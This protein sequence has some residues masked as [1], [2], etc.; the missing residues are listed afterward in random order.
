MKKIT[1]ILVFLLGLFGG[2]YAQCIRTTQY[3]TATVASNNLGL[4]QNIS[5][6]NYTSEYAVLSGLV[7]GSNY[8]FTCVAT[9]VAK[10][11]TVTDL[12][13]AVIAS[14]PSPLTVSAIT[15]AD[16]RVHFSDD[17]A[18]ASTASCHVTTVQLLLSC[19][20]PTAA[21]VSA[22]TTTGATFTWTAGGSET[23]WEVLVLPLGA[24]APVATD[25]GTA[26]SSATYTE[27]TLNPSSSYQFYVRANCGSEF[28]PWSAA[29]SFASACDSVTDF[30]QN[31]DA[32]VAFPAC[33][34]RVGT[35]GSTNV[36]ASASAPSAPNV[37]YL[38][39]SSATSQGLVMMPL[40][41]NA[42]DG[43]HQLRFK[44]RGNFTAGGFIEVGYLTDSANAASFVSLQS[45]A[46]TSTTVYDNFVAVLGTAPGT[47]QT[48][49]FRHLGT[50][51]YSVLIDDVSWE[52]VPTV[53]PSCATNIVST[54]DTACGNYATT[55]TW[56][57]VPDANGYKLSMGTSPGASDV[58][59]NI[60][61]NANNY[62]FVG[63]FNAT[64]YY[65]IIPFNGA[66]NATGCTEETFTTFSSG[67]YCT[68]V[69]TSNDNSGITNVQLGTTDFPTTDVTYVDNTANPID[70][71][72][73]VNTNLQVTFATGF[74]Y[75][76]NV[77]IDFNDN[78]IFDST[79]LVKS[80]I[81]TV[82]TNPNTLDASFIMPVTAT[83]GQHRMR[84]GTADSGQN[85][86]NPCFS[87]TYGV[88]IDFMAN[89]VPAPS[90][91][92]PMSLVASSVT[93]ASATVSWTASTSTPANGY[94]YFVS[95]SN[96]APLATDAATG[97]VIGGIT[98]VNLTALNPAT[99]YYVWVRSICSTTDSSNW[100][101]AVSFTTQCV[102]LTTL[103]W[104]EN[105]DALTVGTN[106]FPTC[107]AYSNTLSTWSIDATNVTAYSGANS[108]RRT[109]STNG[110]A[111]TPFATL[112]A[113]TSYT[114]SYYMRTKDTTVG[115]DLTIGVGNGQTDADM[116][117][118]LST[119]TGYQNPTW[120]KFTFEYTPTTSGDYSFGVHV[121]APVAPNGINFDDFMLEST[122]SCHEPIALVSSDV[123][124]TTAMV[125]WTDSNNPPASNG[126][127][128]FVSTTNVAPNSTV[129]A[130]G[131]VTAGMTMANLTNLTSATTYYVWVRSLCSATEK[132]AWSIATSFST[133]CSGATVPY[134]QDFESA[135]VPALPICTSVENV[136]TGNNWTTAAN[137]GS[138]FTTNAL[139]YGYNLS[140]AADAWYYT[141]PIALIGGT[142]YSIAYDYGN[143]STTYVESL[144]VAYGS[145]ANAASMTNSI[146]DY[147]SI[148]TGTLTNESLTFTPTD[149]GN[150]YFGFNA[151]SIANQWN[152]YVDNIVID[153]VLANT[154]FDN[155]TFTYFP[156]PVKDIL[157][158]SY[159]KNITN[160]AVYNL[161][162]QQVII[163]TVNGNQSQLDMSNLSNGTYMVKVTADNQIK[164]I[165]VIKQ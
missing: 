110:W 87:G 67:C 8:I 115:Y 161:L 66:G 62:S 130:T 107:W 144:K 94:E 71:A 141:Q 157:H 19:P 83:L 75:D 82:N 34:A 57:A 68:S 63:N 24:P 92:A 140:N 32:A 90:C 91:L 31:F 45:F 14:G 30:S 148:N 151:Y 25:S 102:A 163:K 73:G 153:V 93:S 146:A 139:K 48:L 29:L 101:V 147:A 123:T 6:C 36:Q 38:Y 12:S 124:G 77:W 53:V 143:N 152:L 103:P 64:Y 49:A 72:Q 76:T 120:T 33:W 10:Y 132:S 162:G 159:D 81:A 60:T 121:V 47:N 136:G 125:T 133:A 129:V 17:A 51:A 4:A 39:G 86:P 11:V 41:S 88:T 42:G 7:V 59:N 105:F 98:T 89:I 134:T 35:G 97:S 18:C 26:T 20:V 1:F 126:Y 109:W 156:N 50:P 117:T 16:V 80:V 118:I 22:I 61:V 28:S 158:L 96:T 3:P 116:T 78:F 160:V 119:T 69:P 70:L 165:K 104:M 40:V 114:F 46:T 106:V 44:A 85:P 138:G 74:T 37:L 84:L 113:G 112:T 23:A 150:Y 131:S 155:S 100:S 142:S 5:T 145:A 21:A 149:S 58:L 43:S 154:T 164:T 15:A 27:T 56:D 55:I 111:F 137:P 99:L 135:V 13:D 79:E 122:P 108:L 127:E 95:T 65:K 2:S 9:G 54:P 52:P 128:Y